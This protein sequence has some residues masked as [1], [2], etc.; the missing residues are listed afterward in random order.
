MTRELAGTLTR[1]RLTARQSPPKC[2]VRLRNRP[3][4]QS[5][6]G[7]LA[8]PVFETGATERTV[9]R[10]GFEVFLGFGAGGIGH[11]GK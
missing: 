3:I 5:L 4:L 7:D 11:L 10:S 1:A 2:M 9:T 8:G 6:K